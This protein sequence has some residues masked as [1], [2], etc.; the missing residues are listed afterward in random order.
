VERLEQLIHEGKRW[1]L[2]IDKETIGF[3]A[4]DWL[5]AFMK[6][7]QQHPEE[8]SSYEKMGK[9]LGLLTSLFV[10]PDLWKVQNIY[11]SIGKKL[12]GPM[13]EKADGGDDLARRWSEVFGQLGFRL[14]VS[15]S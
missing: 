4:K 5:N 6:K 10:E 8:V 13:K 1:H 3:M 14:R 2:E 12:Y 7:V 11:F 15:V 9:V